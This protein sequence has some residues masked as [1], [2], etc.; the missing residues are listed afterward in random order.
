MST[1]NLKDLQWILA[2]LMNL[3]FGWGSKLSPTEVA[4]KVMG[5]RERA[6]NQKSLS[7]GSFPKIHELKLKERFFCFW[8]DMDYKF[9]F[10]FPV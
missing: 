4:D 3:C 5:R 1:V 10:S 7:H 9:Y 8:K 2:S 6:E